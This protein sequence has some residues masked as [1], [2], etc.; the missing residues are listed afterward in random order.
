M[1]KSVNVGIVGMGKMGIMHAGL[2]NSFEDVQVRAV[3]D[4]QDLLLNFIGQQLPS[5]RT[6]KDYT[7]MLR[8]EQL[9]LVFITTPTSLHT[10]IGLDCVKAEIPFFVEK[11]LGI[12]AE[13]CVP[14]VEAISAKPV[15]NMI[16]YSVVS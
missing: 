7:D 14:L 3:A 9:D 6:Y 13:D 12:S 2:L 11:P 16:G 10:Q 15:I 8:N 5:M 4:T 1:N